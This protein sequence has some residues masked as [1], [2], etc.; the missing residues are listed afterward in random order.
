M[1]AVEDFFSIK[2]GETEN[3]YASRLYQVSGQSLTRKQAETV[4]RELLANDIVQQWK[5][6]SPEEWDPAQGL[7]III[8]KVM[9]EHT[10]TVTEIAIGSDAELLAISDE[11]SLALNPAD[12]PT[13][14][15]Y[16]LRPDV[17]EARKTAGLS[18]PTDVELEYI[19]QARSDHCNHNTFN[20]LFRY[21]DLETGDEAG[22]RQPFQDLHRGSDQE[23]GRRKGLGCIRSVGQRWSGPPG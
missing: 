13:I 12:I 8:P 5:V 22:H 19:S 10:P 4:A 17:L 1:E 14:R 6:F 7:G 16:F 21:R 15:E 20:G 23:A 3:I 2:L 9:L 11:R 18:L